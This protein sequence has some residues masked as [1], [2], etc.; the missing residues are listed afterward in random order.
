MDELD[1]QLIEEA[2][3]ELARRDFF[4]FCNL[5]APD[6]YKDERTFLVD[7]CNRLQ[8]FYFDSSKK[9]LVINMPPRHGKSRTAT[10]F[11][12]WLL[13]IDPTTK[14]MTG[15][16]NEDLSVTFARA[17]R[18]AIAEQKTE[19]VL[20]YCDI[21]PQTRIKQGNASVSKWSLEGSQQ[22]NY[23]ATSP[24]GTATGFGAKVVIIDD[25]IKNDEE[26]YNENT[27]E[28]QYSW[29]TNTMLSR[30]ENDFKIIIIMTRWSTKDLAGRILEKYPEA[31]HINYK[32]LQD[33]GNMLCDE[34]LSKDDFEFKT[35]Q[36]AMNEDIVLANYQ[37]EPIDIKGRLYT[38][39]QTYGDIPRDGTGKPLFTS[40]RNYTDTADMGEDYLCSI[41]YGVFDHQAYILDVLYTKEPMEV[42][43]P[44]VA[45]MLSKDDVRKAR[46][47]SNNGGRGFARNVQREL[48]SLNNRRCRIEWFHQ[49]ENKIARILSNS[50]G[51][52]QDVLFP[53]DWMR[54]FP[55]F[56]RDLLKFQKEGKNAHDDCADALT[57]VYENIDTSGGV[58]FSY[59]KIL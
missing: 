34:I 16:Y 42:T 52:M 39:I 48:Q 51:V 20:S 40:I 54:R 11:C 26:A 57:G 25:L 22:A 17:V 43:E 14:I 1:K 59:N 37:Q 24:K 46:I 3:K 6:F 23:L 8:E 47:E 50:T 5:F 30:T 49:G 33:D 32:A 53:K 2:Q 35:K 12:Q 13:G 29:F 9:V 58:T 15:S 41:D 18:D 44:A 27:L 19:G 55:D 56:A 36:M 21:F 10:L 45:R 31:E 28:K 4:Y 38:T 7:L